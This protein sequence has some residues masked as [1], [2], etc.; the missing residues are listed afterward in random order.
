MNNKEANQSRLTACLSPSGEQR[1]IRADELTQNARDVLAWAF[2]QEL[3][4]SELA[5]IPMTAVEVKTG[6]D[7]VLN[8]M[9]GGDVFTR[10]GG[11]DSLKYFTH[12][13][14][15]DWAVIFSNDCDGCKDRGA[16]IVEE[17]SKK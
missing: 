9:L 1:S 16:K 10:H 17:F 8:I 2:N 11:S 12:K 7:D 14:D 15:P 6:D 13:D 5:P 4:A 3:S